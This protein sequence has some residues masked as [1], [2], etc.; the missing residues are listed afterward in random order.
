MM[1]VNLV[2]L[3][4]PRSGGREATAVGPAAHLRF[5]LVEDLAF[6][7]DVQ[8]FSDRCPGPQQGLR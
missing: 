7:E 3:C 8:D 1:I 2:R 6:I 5:R 4:R